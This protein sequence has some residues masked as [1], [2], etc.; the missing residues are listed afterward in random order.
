[1]AV[2]YLVERIELGATTIGGIVSA[3]FSPGITRQLTSG[4]NLIDPTLHAISTVEPDI[5]FTT[6]DIK[7]VLDAM[8]TTTVPHLTIAGSPNDVVLYLQSSDGATRG[9]NSSA[10]NLTLT[11]VAGIVT[12]VRIVN[13]GGIAALEC[14]VDI[15]SGDV[16]ATKPVTIAANSNLPGSSAAAASLWRFD[17]IQDVFGGVVV[18]ITNVTLDISIDFGIS[19]AKDNSSPSLYPDQIAIDGFAPTA[20][21]TTTA[22]GTELA[23]TGMAGQVSTGSGIAIYLAAVAADGTISATGGLTFAFRE[24]SPWHP[25]SV[26]LDGLATVSYTITGLGGSNVV[27]EPPLAYANGAAMPTVAAQRTAE[28]FKFGTAGDATTAAFEVTGGSVDFGINVDTHTPSTLIWPDTY[29]ILERTPSFTLR[30]RKLPDVL[31]TAI[32][33]GRVIATDFQLFLRKI[34]TNGEPLANATAEH[35]KL[36]IAAGVIEQDDLSGDHGSVAEGGVKVI[37]ASATPLAIATGVAIT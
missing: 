37:S 4:S 12:P 34:T 26:N 9:S 8:T 24:N 11:V 21:F 14:R 10:D 23:A 7:T 36:T 18:P 2:K 13:Q 17:A 27:T 31:L 16:G 3:G 20:T 6:L 25:D 30:T 28:A 15:A 29:S 19:V 1:M 22:V 35:V 32:N 33:E 5:T